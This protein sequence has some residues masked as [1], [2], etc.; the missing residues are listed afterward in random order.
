MRTTMVVDEDNN[1]NIN[2]NSAK[3]AFLNYNHQTF[4]RFSLCNASNFALRLELNA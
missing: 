2:N 1:N 4:L 3:A